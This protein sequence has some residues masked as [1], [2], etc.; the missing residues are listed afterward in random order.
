MKVYE[1]LANS[2]YRLELGTCFALLGDGNMHWASSLSDLGNRFVYTR[3]EH[4]AVAAATAYARGSGKIGLA[5]VTCGPGLTQIMTILPIAVRAKVPLIIF[6]GEAPLNKNW[7]NQMISQAPFVEACG[8][9]Y[10]A[11]HDLNAIIDSTYSAVNLAA[12]E[13]RPVV[14]GVPLDLQQESFIGNI[15]NPLSK[16]IIGPR[17]VN[18]PLKKDIKDAAKLISNS[19]KSIILAGLGASSKASVSAIEKLAHL[20][21]SLVA[22]TLPA[23]GLFH[24]KHFCLGV[25]G[26]YSS[27]L[28][29][30][31]FASSETVVAIGARM[32]SHTFDNGNLTPNAK[33]I[34]IN[35]DAR[36]Y[37]QGR[38]VADL[39]IK[40][41][42]QLATNLLIDEIK[43][44][45]QKSW[46]TASMKKATLSALR[47]PAYTPPNDGLMHPIEVIGT[48][49]KI[50]PKHCHII[51][52][53]GHCAYFTAQMNDHPQ[54]HFTVI[55]EFGA[56]G[57]GT[58]FALGIA[59]RYLDRPVI[60]IEG[61][62]SA[63]MN[64][65]E[66]E[67][68]KRYNMNILTIVLNDGGFGSEFHKLRATGASLEGSI[69]GR[70]DFAAIGTSFGLI[71]STAKTSLD[72]RTAIN[73]FLEDNRPAICDVHISDKVASP[74]ITRT[75]N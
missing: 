12:T 14:L 64:I 45:P 57:N 65:Q 41:D 29:R 46:R 60:L 73:Y 74:Q 58:S 16:P 55:R 38:K 17:C 72:L 42:A 43:N 59:E 48:L 21:G 54:S 9:E 47:L 39:S 31:I 2:F 25:A 19:K 23:R 5:S 40:A 44:I 36:S 13:C 34:Q 10:V 27:D 6:A 33:V 51:N 35:L 1:A 15:K 4:A 66:L 37:V 75:N 61:D 24:D 7:Y 11:L 8:A 71:G 53:S 62:G 22:T 69:F 52:T 26:G 68:M 18:K 63:M 20:T 67:T 30:K 70:P 50:I 3:H 32:A 28:A 56:I 49:K